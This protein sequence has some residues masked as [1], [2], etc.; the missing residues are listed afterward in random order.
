M[1]INSEGILHP[2]TC[3]H[4]KS[5]GRPI[6]LVTIS[7]RLLFSFVGDGYGYFYHAGCW[8]NS[9]VTDKIIH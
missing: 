8:N 6:M 2:P 9:F 5:E 7:V 1:V 4:G 3:S